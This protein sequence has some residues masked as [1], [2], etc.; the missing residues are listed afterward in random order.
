[1]HSDRYPIRRAELGE[2]PVDLVAGVARG[3]AQ[4]L[5]VRRAVA[6]PTAA[7]TE[8]RHAD[9]IANGET[10]DA[11]R[12]RR[13]PTHDLVARH[14]RQLRLAELAVD[15]VEIRPTHATRVDAHQ[16][17]AVARTR[18]R[19]LGLSERSARRLQL[20]RTH[21]SP[22]A[23]IGWIAAL[24]PTAGRFATHWGEIGLR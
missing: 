13:H 7:A 1:M 20:H 4:V 3:V 17:L 6:A 5:P 21:V 10:L 18:R 11:R 24:R 16:H 15:D 14:E 12:D 2:A 19:D 23:S 9:P 22:T 8:P